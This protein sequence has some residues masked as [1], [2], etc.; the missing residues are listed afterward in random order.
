[1]FEK[2]YQFAG[3]EGTDAVEDPEAFLQSF[4][5]ETFKKGL[6]RIH[7]INDIE[8]WTKIVEEA[9][10]KYKGT[11]IVFGYDWLGRQ[12][13][14]N[15]HTGKTLL[16]E[17]GTGEVLNIPA[18]FIMLHDEEIADYSADSLASD[19]FEEWYGSDAGCD[20]P[21]EK[22][23]GYKVPL[24]L[25]GEDNISNLELSDMEVYWGM[26]GDLIPKDL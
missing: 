14:E 4:S 12:F 26:M 18:D 17:P 10:P 3:I 19:F 13:A 11:I 16:F 8:K 5:G 24:F 2:F 9:F 7:N 1:M 6:Y 22:C 20:I 23:V 21:H 25:N 15:I